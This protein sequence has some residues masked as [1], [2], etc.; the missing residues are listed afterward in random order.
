MDRYVGN[1]FL[2]PK[3]AHSDGSLPVVRTR[4]WITL[5]KKVGSG[6]AF[7]NAY[8]NSYYF[9]FFCVLQIRIRIHFFTL[10]SGYEKMDPHPARQDEKILFYTLINKVS[11]QDI[12]CFTLNEAT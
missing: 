5:K 3:V 11:H 2:Q 12:K 9:A 6:S 1:N 8:M 4:F 10:G 7:Q